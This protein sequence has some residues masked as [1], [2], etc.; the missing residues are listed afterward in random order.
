MKH[1]LL[2]LLIVLG[3]LLPKVALAETVQIGKLYYNLSQDGTASVVRSLSAAYAGDID[4]PEAVT[5]DDITYSVTAI[6]FNAF[7]GC[8]A[9][10]AITL[11]KSINT[12]GDV[13][14]SGCSSLTAITVEEGNAKY[15]SRD[16]CN[17]I[18]ETSTN[19]LLY[20]CNTT[21]IP[22][23]VT[24]IGIEAFSGCSALTTITLPKSL[25]DIG[26]RAFS[27]CTSL[28]TITL[29]S[30]LKGLDTNAFLD[31]TGLIAIT[32]PA[33]VEYIGS[34]VFNGCSSLTAITVEEGNAKYDSRDGC[35]A[36]IETAINTLLCGCNTTVIPESVT[37][38]DD[39]AFLG[40]G[41]KAITIPA[42]VTYIGNQTF[43][44]CSS[45][46]A[47]TVEE[48]NAKYDSRDGCNAII[49][50]ATNT[51]LCGCNTTVIPES[52]TRIGF[53]AFSGCGLK[54][55]FIHK[56]VES[57]GYTAFSSCSSLNAIAVE[58]GNAKYDSRD[59][60]N[61]IIETATNTLLYGCNTT[62]IPDG[63]TRILEY[64][65]LDCTGLT[66]ITI[67][68]SVA[69][70]GH[71]AFSGCT[72]LAD[73]ANLAT[74]PQSINSYTFSNYTTL[75]VKR[76]YKSV[77]EAANYWQNFTIVDDCEPTIAIADKQ[78]YEL[79]FD[80]TYDEV[81][82]TRTFD[83]TSWQALYVPFAM[84][85]E[86]WSADFDIA[87][88]VNVI[89]YDDDDDGNFERT[90]LVVR[91]LTKGST[92]ANCPY[93][94]R[95]K[96]TDAYTLTLSGRTVKAATSGSVECRSTECIYTFMGTYAPV[97]T[98][99]TN[100][101]YAMAGGKL[102]QCDDSDVTLSP[103]RWYLDITPIADDYNVATKARTITI[104]VEGEDDTAIATLHADDSVRRAYD[105]MG[106]RVTEGAKGISIMDGKKI[107]K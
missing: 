51:L 9:L 31:C 48:G 68:A 73:V 99:Y 62:I 12:I 106:R 24:A 54:A 95:A 37:R 6:G 103:Q 53:E 50:T 90:H 65:F 32:L 87:K 88:I 80:N 71:K 105:L 60:C 94:I 59:G 43:N 69:S 82:Y 23:G 63:V 96:R 92:K 97:T 91:K 3:A 30:N 66:T 75:H 25:N 39:S 17:A 42:S 100:G 93:L 74:Q 85:Y 47:I 49:E 107:I 61:A 98:M 1:K 4:I 35:N 67:P 7:S 41:L 36:I 52:V 38:I 45:L 26:V 44:D 40:C 28:T 5:H 33:S 83:N 34:S 10:T 55:I 20:G 81:T 101:Y 72:S 22:D 56:G 2:L 76:G 18:I 19:T 70:I 21:V 84:R 16:G 8:S 29:P 64:A 46:T 89:Q 57:I 104:L 77:Y 58:E 15:D 11:P 102:Q 79:P 78:A 86:E 13:A 14:F 27:G